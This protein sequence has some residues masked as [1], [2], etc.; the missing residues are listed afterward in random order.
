L[1]NLIPHINWRNPEV[2]QAMLNV[3]RFWL[4][5]EVDGFRMDVVYCIMKDPQWCDNPLNTGTPRG[6]K[7][8]GWFDTQV[9]L[10]DRGHPDVHTIL[11]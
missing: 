9:H 3:L 4:E 2:V 7:S 5:R 10:Y 11:K 6:N 8:L 1:D